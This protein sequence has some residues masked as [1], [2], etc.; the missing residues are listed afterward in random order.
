M[1]GFI[2]I[3]ILATVVETIGREV[4]CPVTRL[5]DSSSLAHAKA[6]RVLNP[7]S[8]EGPRA[9]RLRRMVFCYRLPQDSAQIWRGR[10][11]GGEIR[12]A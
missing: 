12:A 3:T 1:R 9:S 7:I 5:A 8:G 2:L 6:T 11:T 10:A 4:G